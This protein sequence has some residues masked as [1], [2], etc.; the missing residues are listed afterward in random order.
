MLDQ[1]R[2]LPGLGAGCHAEL[3]LQR[4]AATLERT[5]CGR[6]IAAQ[7]VQP[8]QPAMGVLER[9]ILGHQALGVGERRRDA[10]LGFE[11]GRDLGQRVEPRA[12]PALAR[13]AHPV[14][15]AGAVG[16]VEVA[17]Q[18]SACG[19]DVAGQARLDGGEVVLDARRQGQH[20]A[21][22]D[23]VAAAAAAQLEQALPQAA[24]LPVGVS[25]APEER[26]RLAARRRSVERDQ[27]QQR[28][29]VALELVHAAVARREPRRAGE[30]QPDRRRCSSRDWRRWSGCS[31]RGARCLRHRVLHAAASA[32]RRRPQDAREVQ[33]G[34]L[35]D[36]AGSFMSCIASTTSRT[37]P[38]QPGPVQ[39]LPSRPPSV[40]Y[41]NGCRTCLARPGTMHLGVRLHQCAPWRHERH[42]LCGCFA[43]C[44]FSSRRVRAAGLRR[45]LRQ[46]LE[47]KR[48]G[49]AG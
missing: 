1:L 29:L 4:L 14:V 34:H 10:A 19:V 16:V 28:G 11:A 38:T 23:H 7:V 48:R 49:H 33:A 35:L 41:R 44:W 40:V 12:A 24:A 45:Q 15:E 26:G 5:E 39:W 37:C 21:R 43:L 36:D 9:R 22:G 6:A 46:Q 31:F 2:E 18:R 25:V 47:A 17:E 30:L 42:A 27:R 32:S 3:L 8:H 13:A 20:L